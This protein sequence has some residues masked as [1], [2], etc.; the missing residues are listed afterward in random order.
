MIPSSAALRSTQ[1]ATALLYMVH[2]TVHYD[3]ATGNLQRYLMDI[4]EK[5]VTVNGQCINRTQYNTIEPTTL[6]RVSQLVLNDL[7]CAVHV[8]RFLWHSFCAADAPCVWPS[9]V[10]CTRNCPVL[11]TAEL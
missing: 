7:N 11:L 3:K 1:R 5:T 4:G 9:C 8:S 2:H 6:F 10:C